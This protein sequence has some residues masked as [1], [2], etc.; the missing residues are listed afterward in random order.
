[1]GNTL[2]PAEA[3]QRP[4]VHTALNISDDPS[5]VAASY[6]LVLADPDST[7]AASKSSDINNDNAGKV[8]DYLHYIVS[9]LRISSDHADFSQ[10]D[11]DKGNEILP[12]LG[13]TLPNGG[14]KHRFVYILFK[15]PPRSLIKSSNKITA[16]SNYANGSSSSGGPLKEGSNNNNNN[17]EKALTAYDAPERFA[18]GTGLRVK[19]WALKHSLAPVAV[20]FYY[21]QG[22]DA[23]K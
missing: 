18:F 12:Y 10:L 13:P 15:E 22:Q 23:Q 14:G 11:L 2:T 16:S 20:N 17:N 21:A 5:L 8:S 6:T 9:G 19:Q 4:L 1:M 7:I 3:R